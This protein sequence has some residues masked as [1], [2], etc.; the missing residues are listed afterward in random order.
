MTTLETNP[1]FSCTDDANILA[2]TCST[3]EQV[4]SIAQRFFES[5]EST[6]A[7]ANGEVFVA[8]FVAE[9]PAHQATREMLLNGVYWLTAHPHSTCKVIP[10]E[11]SQNQLHENGLIQSM[12]SRNV[13]IEKQQVDGD[14]GE[15]YGYMYAVRRSDVLL[16]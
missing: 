6:D 3:E 8:Y 2:R 4:E 5:I 9:D 10:P 15:V 14:T 7:T 12:L 16:V 11:L 13:L 1:P